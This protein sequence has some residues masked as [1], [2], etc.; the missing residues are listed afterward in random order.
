MKRHTNDRKFEIE[1][2]EG[3][4]KRPLIPVPAS[5]Y[6]EKRVYMI[7]MALL[8][9]YA[10]GVDDGGPDRKTNGRKKKGGATY[11]A[12]SVMYHRPL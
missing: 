6:R 8:D 10:I 2:E 3:D 7:S 12:R 5:Q 9:A 11:H 4:H 1:K